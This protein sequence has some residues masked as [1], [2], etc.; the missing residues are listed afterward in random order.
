MPRHEQELDLEPG[1][2]PFE[3]LEKFSAARVRQLCQ[4]AP[5]EQLH[6]PLLGRPDP[7]ERGGQVAGAV[8]PCLPYWTQPGPTRHVPFPLQGELDV[9]VDLTTNLEHNKWAAVERWLWRSRHVR[10]VSS[11]LRCT[12]TEPA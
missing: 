12:H 2:N 3:A 11:S 8:P 7:R 5:A 4:C 6:A 10:I 9:I 1:P